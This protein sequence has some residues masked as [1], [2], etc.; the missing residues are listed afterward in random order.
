MSVTQIYIILLCGFEGK[1]YQQYE[2]NSYQF[3]KS[4]RHPCKEEE[5]PGIVRWMGK[6]GFESR[7]KFLLLS[8]YYSIILALW[9]IIEI[10]IKAN[11]D[12]NTKFSWN[13]A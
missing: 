2:T 11:L 5:T 7:Q 6:V 3:C 4:P 1:C 13:Y 10:V 8:I 9:D 12:N